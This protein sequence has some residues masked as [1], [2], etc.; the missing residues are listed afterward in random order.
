[1]Q[2]VLMEPAGITPRLQESWART[3]AAAYET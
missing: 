3:E 1:M 2:Q